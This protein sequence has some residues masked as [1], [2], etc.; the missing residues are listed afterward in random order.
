[1]NKD[2]A[3][4]FLRKLCEMGVVTIDSIDDVKDILQDVFDLGYVQ[5]FEHGEH[6][7]HSW[8]KHPNGTVTCE[9]GIN[10]IYGPYGENDEI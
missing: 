2:S 9:C 7:S 8:T 5:G 3:Q 10:L 1:M 6:F 4:F